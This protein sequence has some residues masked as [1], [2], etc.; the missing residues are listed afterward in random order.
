MDIINAKEMEKSVHND[1]KENKFNQMVDIQNKFIKERMQSG[2]KSVIWI[3]SDKEYYH[4]D[5]ER[6]WFEEFKERATQQ[7]KEAGYKIKGIII[8]W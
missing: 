3:F 2:E 7:F 1:V 5:L 4:N 8:T 6:G